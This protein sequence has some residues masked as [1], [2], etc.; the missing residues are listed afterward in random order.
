MNKLTATEHNFIG[1]TLAACLTGI[2]YLVGVQNGWI[3]AVNWWEVFAVFTSFVCT[4]LCV[5]QSRTNYIWGVITTAAWS[6]VFYEIGLYG[7]MAL[8]LYLV[9]TLAWGWFRWGKDT[10]TRP[11]AFVEPRWWFAYLGLTVIVWYAMSQVSAYFGGTLTYADSLILAASILA[12]F[13]LDQKKIETWAVWILVN[14]VAIQTYMEAGLTLTAFQ[15]VFFL[16]NAFYGAAMWGFSMRKKSAV[17]H[18]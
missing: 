17:A 14:V 15:Y 7:S 12:Q 8:N 3:T 16:A 6:Y 2:S 5:M 11:V 4:Y 18:G 1:I 13:L 10:N 9:P